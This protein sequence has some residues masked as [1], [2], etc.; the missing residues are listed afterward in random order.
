MRVLDLF[1]GIGGFS[2]GL[3]RTGM[4]TAAFCETGLFQ[5]AVLAERW[6]NVPCFGDVRSLTKEKLDVAG[7]NDIDVICGGFPCQDLSTSGSGRGLDGE[8]SGL[9]RE[10][11]R[12]VDEL[13]PSFVIMENSPE[14]LNGW[15]GELF[16]PLAGLGYDAEW[17]CI[18]AKAAG[19]DHGRKRVWIVAYPSSFGQSRP[20]GLLNAIHPAPD[21]YREAS[22]LVDAV[23]RGSVPFVCER[24]DGVPAKMARHQLGALGNAVVP[25]IPEMIGRA[26]MATQTA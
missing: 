12:L 26:I 19:A 18:R 7:I 22:G 24:H 11:I 5:R 20:G 25:Q 23:Q 15:V 2:L 9:G 21:A 14:L 3:E 6:P 10:I 4:T 13:R 16:A 17:E 8:R 1:S